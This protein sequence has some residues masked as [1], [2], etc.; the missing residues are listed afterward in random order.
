M[1]QVPAAYGPTQEDEK[2]PPTRPD[3]WLPSQVERFERHPQ[4]VAGQ[5][6]AAARSAD[7]TRYSMSVPGGRSAGYRMQLQYGPLDPH[8]IRPRPAVPAGYAVEASFLT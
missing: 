7:G 4:L 8:R 5:R 3:F 2:E 6:G 1:R